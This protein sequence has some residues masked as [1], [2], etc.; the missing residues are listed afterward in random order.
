MNKWWEFVRATGV[1]LQ[2]GAGVLVRRIFS[3]VVEARA[4]LGFPAQAKL[5]VGVNACLDFI[6]VSY[7]AAWT[8]L[9]MRRFVKVSL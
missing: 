7:D 6:F 2:L 9:E 3:R 8:L 1:H 5:R 4:I